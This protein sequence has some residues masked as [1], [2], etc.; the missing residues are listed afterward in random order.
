[1][2]SRDREEED[3]GD[4][5]NITRAARDAVHR[6]VEANIATLVQLVRR[7]EIPPDT[8]HTMPD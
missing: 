3:G 7:W 6:L 1:V 5:T 4:L 2:E 8:A